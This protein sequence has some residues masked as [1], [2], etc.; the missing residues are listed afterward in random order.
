[1]TDS[2]KLRHECLLYLYGSRPLAI[3]ADSI[4]R[5]SRRDNS[6]A[7]VFAIAEIRAELVFLLDEGLAL[8]VTD[9]ATGEVRYRITSKGCNQWETHE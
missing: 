3:S 2:Q 5:Q 8:K 7:E 1:M 9:T 6:G 4:H